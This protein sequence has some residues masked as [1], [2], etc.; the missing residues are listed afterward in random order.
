MIRNYFLINLILLIIIGFLGSKFYKVYSQT[1]NVPSEPAVKQVQKE[2]PPVQSEDKA[3]DASHFQII[4]NMDLFRPARSPYKEDVKQQEAP[5]I[6]PR[7]FGTVILGNE[8]T[9]ILEDSNTKTTRTYRINDSIGGYVISDILE[10]RVLLSWNGERSEVRLREEKK[11]LPPVKPMITPQ[12]PQQMP[13]ST[14]PQQPQIQPQTSPPPVQRPVLPRRPVPRQ[15]P[16]TP[17]EG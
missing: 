11:G 17:P 12:Q 2:T 10:D 15:V 4:S 5:K 1:F 14:Q 13:Q 16:R 9:A 7:L 8:K 6:P 3:L